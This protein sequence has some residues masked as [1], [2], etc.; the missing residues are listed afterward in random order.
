MTFDCNRRGE[1]SRTPELGISTS[2][3]FYSNTL[4]DSD[5]RAA[6]E[7]EDSDKWLT[8]GSSGNK[9]QAFLRAT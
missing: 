3:L 1:L 2:F 6:E 7:E 9:N 4:M 5:G 8:I